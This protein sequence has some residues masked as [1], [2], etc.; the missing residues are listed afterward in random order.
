MD[1][2]RPLRVEQPQG[3]AAGGAEM[4][5]AGTGAAAA[6]VVADVGLVHA[7]VFAA[8]DLQRVGARAQVDCAAAPAGGLAADRAVAVQEWGGRMRF[9]AEAHLAAVA[10]AFEL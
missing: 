6:L 7:Q 3:A 2:I 4:A 9:A 10:G 5:A 8:F 1:E